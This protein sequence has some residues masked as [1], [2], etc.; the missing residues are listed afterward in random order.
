MQIRG[1]FQD[2]K[3]SP[4]RSLPKRQVT[5]FA[6]SDRD[7]AISGRSIRRRRG[8]SQSQAL[9]ALGEEDYT[10]GTRIKDKAAL[11][12]I[13]PS[14]EPQTIIRPCCGREKKSEHDANKHLKRGT[15]G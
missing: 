9:N 4:H 11:L 3:V 6:E 15:N 2:R 1:H 5:K 14:I 7:P 13:N 12:A 8:D 10:I